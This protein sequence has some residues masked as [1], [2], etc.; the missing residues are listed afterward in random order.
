MPVY[1]R[2]LHVQGLLFTCLATPSQQDIRTKACHS[3]IGKL[4]WMHTQSVLM[5]GVEAHH[6]MHPDHH[7]MNND[8]VP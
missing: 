3:E 7:V 6:F 2:T 4:F 5:Q 1:V 8:V